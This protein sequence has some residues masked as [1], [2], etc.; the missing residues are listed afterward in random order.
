MDVRLDHLLAQAAAQ[1]V[2]AGIPTPEARWD[3][4]L[5]AADAF[6]RCAPDLHVD[7][8]RIRVWALLHVH[9][10]E[11]VGEQTA[12]KICQEYRALIDRRAAREPL[13]WIEGTAAFR[14]LTLRVGPGVFIPRPETELVAG[15]AISWL[16][17]A[18]SPVAPENSRDTTSTRTVIDLCAGSGAIGLSIASEVPGVS[19][20][21]VENDPTALT[22]LKKNIAL[23]APRG[24]GDN[25]VQCARG[26]SVRAVQADA[27][28]ANL[29]SLIGIQSNSAMCVVSNPPYVPQ[30]QPVVQPE[31]ARDPASAL[32]GGSADGMKIPRQIVAQAGRLLASGGLC[33]IE[34]D[35]SQGAAMRAACCSIGLTH[36]RTYE[37]GTHRPRWT[38][39]V[40]GQQVRGRSV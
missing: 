6:Q 16:R 1:L 22:W 31:A 35:I 17:R 36:V 8:D 15:A 25:H 39:G 38:Q 37:D 9:I 29:T 19:V 4:Q 12:Q 24:T 13:Q 28:A 10:S 7:V 3:A 26:S 18:V 21:C 5:L 34:H 23:I 20:V 40:M 2:Q 27:T 11:R 14:G 32:Y 33:A 30:S